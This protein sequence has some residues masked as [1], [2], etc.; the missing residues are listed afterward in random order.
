MNIL[1]CT[2]LHCTALHCTALHCTKPGL[3]SLSGKLLQPQEIFPEVPESRDKSIRGEKS[4]FLPGERKLDMP[5]FWA[6][7]HQLP[8]T[9]TDLIQSQRELKTTKGARSFEL[10]SS[11]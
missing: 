5:L 7:L 9:I 4:L 11:F 6:G 1:H 2:A 10:K 3:S 8:V